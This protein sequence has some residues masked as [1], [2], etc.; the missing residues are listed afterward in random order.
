MIQ[1]FL[2]PDPLYVETIRREDA[3][4]DHLY[5]HVLVDN[6]SRA[7]FEIRSFELILDNPSLGCRLTQTFKGSFLTDMFEK[8]LPFLDRCTSPS[9]TVPPNEMRG[10]VSHHLEVDGACHF[11]DIVCRVVGH[12]L[13][14]GK[15]HVEARGHLCRDLPQTSLTLPV[16]GRWWIAGGHTN[17]EPHRRGRLPSTVYAYDF[18]QLGIDCRSFRNSGTRNEDYYAFGAPV[19]AAADGIVEKVAEGYEENAPSCTPS[20]NIDKYLRSDIPMVGNH[21]VIKHCQGEYTLYAHLQPRLLVRA[22][23]YVVRGQELGLLGNS[24]E[25]TEPHLHFH[26]ADGPGLDSGG[27]PI[28][29]ENWKE[30][31]F[32]LSPGIVNRGAI[33][34]REVI[35]STS[36]VNS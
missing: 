8:S 16:K 35:E 27:I 4:I 24:G 7:P 19:L 11:S 26:L 29:F 25:S 23:D 15:I 20:R 32:S 18:I 21:V 1:I 22:G 3:W 17:F 14:A 28:Q 33:L 5:F 36:I 6:L 12:S 10:I 2:R 9:L 34:S 31:A 30:D 13:A